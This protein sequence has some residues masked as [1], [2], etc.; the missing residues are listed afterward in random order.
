MTPAN[1]IIT[2]NLEEGWGALHNS[3]P[4]LQGSP[5]LLELWENI[6]RINDPNQ[7]GQ[8]GKWVSEYTKF[9]KAYAV[10]TPGFHIRN[11]LANSFVP[12]WAGAKFENMRTGLKY[13][14]A[15]DKAKVT[16]VKWEDF[17][18]TVPTEY[19]SALQIGRDSLFGSGGG[20]YSETF[21]EQRG[22]SRLYN[23]WLTNKSA[24][25]GQISDNHARFVLGFDG[26]MQGMDTAMSTAR[27]RRFYF[28]YEDISQLDKDMKKIIPFWIF[29]KNNII[30]QSVNMWTSP[31][32]YLKYESFKRNFRD[33]PPD[34]SDLNYVTRGGG[35]KLPF[36]GGEWYIAPDLGFNRVRSDL[37]DMLQV[38]GLLDKTNPIIKTLGEQVVGK[39]TKGREFGADIPVDN[40]GVMGV[41]QPI[42][43][44]IGLGGTTA[45]GTTGI[46][47]RFLAA[48]TQ[49]LP[50]LNYAERLFP[51]K[52]QQMPDVRLNA[53][54]GFAGLP[55]KRQ[56]ASGQV[57]SVTQLQTLIEEL[58]K[59]KAG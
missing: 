25:L 28:D 35:W 12:F 20:I 21:R 34:N 4:G 7:F 58:L 45:E 41:L 13:Y 50:T 30:T 51:S 46:N 14:V 26:G 36:G 18:K 1:V 32:P 17:L 15:W 23:N 8:V 3:Y 57:S 10:L 53:A 52:T 43:Q 42:L 33:T 54:L 11:A 24:K 49:Q 47:D 56:G 5:E 16:G 44:K 37:T 39:S 59:Q 48:L 27:V 9:F 40:T 29:T 31:Q 6:V 22:A 55:I 19:R 2:R 38:G